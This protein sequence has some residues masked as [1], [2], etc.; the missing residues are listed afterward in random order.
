[1]KS[2]LLRLLGKQ[3]STLAA[4]QPL[5]AR[6]VVVSR[7]GATLQVERLELTPHARQLLSAKVKYIP[8]LKKQ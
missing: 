7:P 3:T 8:G 6:S 5:I 1:M 4:P 2:W